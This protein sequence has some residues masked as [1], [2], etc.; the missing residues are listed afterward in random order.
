[1]P[2]SICCADAPEL[3]KLERFRALGAVRTVVRAPTEG[4]DAILPFLDEYAK[5]SEKLC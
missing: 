4:R 1:M 3:E 2:M 5:L